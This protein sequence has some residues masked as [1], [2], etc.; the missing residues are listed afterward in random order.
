MTNERQRLHVRRMARFVSMARQVERC[1]RRIDGHVAHCRAS[2]GYE[3]VLRTRTDA[4]YGESLPWQALLAHS[5]AARRSVFFTPL[6]PMPGGH[7]GI[8]DQLAVA[9]PEVMRRVVGRWAVE[10]A[11]LHDSLDDARVG[12][13]TSPEQALSAAVGG[14]S[15]ET[16]RYFFMPFALLRAADAHL[17]SAVGPSA[18]CQHNTMAALW[19]WIDLPPR[20]SKQIVDVGA[21]CSFDAEQLRFI[22]TRSQAVADALPQGEGGTPLA[23]GPPLHKLLACTPRKPACPASVG[24]NVATLRAA[25]LRLTCGISTSVSS[26]PL[27]ALRCDL[28]SRLVGQSVNQHR[29]TARLWSRCCA[30]LPAA[31][32]ITIYQ[33][34][35]ACADAEGVAWEA[36][37]AREAVPS[38]RRESQKAYTRSSS[39][40]GVGG[41]VD[42]AFR[43]AEAALTRRMDEIHD[44]IY[45]PL[46]R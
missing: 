34:A 19:G 20:P 31:V 41:P 24:T 11:R 14:R 30:S 38:G 6:G 23:N 17:F 10:A 1:L 32:N 42:G 33:S 21:N 18:Y 8:S 16:L 5:V 15:G 25:A 13:E 29:F 26:S 12:G 39:E 22:V 44:E 36:W 4:V 27:E 37:M 43:A 2:R 46:S 35:L 28:A 3:L 7:G 9:P 40:G 45:R